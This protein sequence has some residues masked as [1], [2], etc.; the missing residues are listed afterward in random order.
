M[1][2]L[3]SVL[4]ISLLSALVT[5]PATLL[6]TSQRDLPVLPEC[7]AVLLGADAPDRSGAAITALEALRET[8]RGTDRAAEADTLYC[9]GLTHFIEGEFP[10]NTEPFR[11]A[12]REF[13]RALV[14]YR[15]VGNREGEARSQHQF[16]L[17][18]F[19]VGDLNNALPSLQQALRTAQAGDDP[20]VEAD[21]QYDLGLFYLERRQGRDLEE[22]AAAFDEAYS[23]YSR[24]TN[25][26]RQGDARVQQAETQFALWELDQA[27]ENFADAADIFNELE[28]PAQEATAI[29]GAAR[30]LHHIGDLYAAESAYNRALELY[31][32]AD[33]AAGQG[34]V[35]AA[36]GN[37]YF[38]SRFFDLAERT[39][40]EALDFNR[41]AGDNVGRSIT[42]SYTGELELSRG[43]LGRAIT[44]FENALEL[45]ESAEDIPAQA[46]A[47]LGLGN[48]R[49]EEARL[50]TDK[51]LRPALNEYGESARL[52]RDVLR[53]LY[54]TRRVFLNQAWAWFN[55]NP[56][57][58]N[59]YQPLF[60]EAINKAREVGDIRGE[61]ESMM[62][63]G[64]V[65]RYRNEFEQA[66][67]RFE[68]AADRAEDLG[69]PVLIG[70][71][72]LALG[73][74]EFLRSRYS[75]ARDRFETAQFNF[76]DAVADFPEIAVKEAVATMRQGDT[77][78]KLGL[79]RDAL[80]Y[81][82]RTLES[83]DS[84]RG[85]RLDVA[86]ADATNAYTSLAIGSL[87][88]ELNLF[89]QASTA[90]EE[91]RTTILG[92]E[93]RAA[94]ATVTALLGDLQFALRDYNSA[95]GS[96]RQAIRLGEQSGNVRAEALGLR[97]IG[98]IL[99]ATEDG[100]ELQIQ[101][102]YERALDR[103]RSISDVDGIRRVF[104]SMGE[105][106][107]LQNDLENAITYFAEARDNADEVGDLRNA[108]YAT[109][110]L[111]Y[112]YTLA[113]DDPQGIGATRTYEQALVQFREQDEY[114]GEG[115]ALQGLGELAMRRSQ[116]AAAIEYFQ[117]MES[118]FN[119]AEN[120][121]GQ[122]QAKILI[123]R[124][125]QDQR[126]LDLA[127]DSYNE[128][129]CMLQSFADV[130]ESVG[131]AEEA[132]RCLQD[133]EIDLSDPLVDVR[134]GRLA[135]AEGLRAR[136]DIYRE[137]EIYTLA[138]DDLS[139]AEAMIDGLA[140][141]DLAQGR[142]LAS[143]GDLA[144]DLNQ[145]QDA[146]QR[147]ENV[148][149]IGVRLRD[150]ST[151]GLGEYGLAR[152][153][154]ADPEE[155]DR[156]EEERT[157]SR[158][159]EL[160][161]NQA[162]NP[163]LA[164]QVAVSL[165]ESF[166]LRG[167]FQDAETWYLTARNEAVEAVDPVGEGY[168][169]LE[170]G[171]L[172]TSRFRFSEA[173]SDYSE[174]VRL[175]QRGEDDLGRGQALYRLAE[176]YLQQVSYL[177]SLAQYQEALALYE[178]NGDLIGQA[179]TL[180]R[181]GEAY[182]RQ[183]RLALALNQHFLALE[184]LNRAKDER[185]TSEDEIDPLTAAT[186]AR[187]L[188]NIGIVRLEMGQ[189]DNAGSALTAAL[190]L[191]VGSGDI[192]AETTTRQLIGRLAFLNGDYVGAIDIYN[193]VAR[194]LEGLNAVQTLGEL[195]ID[196]G[197]AEFRQAFGSRQ[198]VI[199]GVSRA[200]ISYQRALDVA[201]RLG[202][203]LLELKAQQSLGRVF[204]WL[205]QNGEGRDRLLTALDLADD[206][207]APTLR[208]SI[209]VDLG[210]LEEEAGN[211]TQAITYY[212]QAVTLFEDVYADIRLEPGQI[213]YASQ[214][215]LPYHRLVVL[216]FESEPAKALEYAE[217]GRARSLLYQFGTEQVDFG[218]GSDLLRA[219]QEQRQQIIGIRQQIEANALARETEPNAEERARLE[220]A[221]DD[222]RRTSLELQDELVIIQEQIDTQNAVLAQVTQVNVRS[223]AEIQADLAVGTTILSY[224][225]VPPNAVDQG[226]VYAFV[227]DQ[228]Q[229]EA[230]KLSV[231]PDTLQ[232]LVIDEFSAQRFE[233]GNSLVSLYQNLVVP[234]ESLLTNEQVVVVPHG[235]LNQ[236]PFSALT[237]DKQTFFNDDRSLSYAAS[238]TIYSLLADDRDAELGEILGQGLVFGNP[239]TPEF[240]REA[241]SGSSRG[242]L[243][244]LPGAEREAEDISELMQVSPLLEEDATE[245]ALWVQG[246][247]AKVIHIAAHGIFNP[248]NPLASFLALADDEDNDGSLQVREIYSLGLRE[249]QPLVVLSACDTAVG[250][251]SQS[252]DLQSL[253]G[254]FLISGARGV[255]ASLW[256]VDDDATQ[257][258]MT[259][260]YENLVGGE[261]TVAQALKAAQ[262][263]IRQDPRWSAPDYWAAF[264]LVGLPT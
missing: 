100:T 39:L 131:Q 181:I 78:M 201:R 126:R 119:N 180:T 253:S 203:K 50:S 240:F 228:E 111:A 210:L 211:R 239:T 130:T 95:E 40:E 191:A 147:F 26:E 15:E 101:E 219:W 114:E 99:V 213:A 79:Y 166:A 177:N 138:E 193:T 122:A 175:F 27:S 19:A 58:Q 198:S 42:L 117:Q 199:D 220:V 44:N 163:A 20:A 129:L 84:Y 2:R 162:P 148:R 189:L 88:L 182:R 154:T 234:V 204:N 157:Y 62:A 4:L 249:S 159:L 254:A 165:A 47:H 173:I 149:A 125:Q 49:A 57:R 72:N 235:V 195:Y 259:Y 164:R 51:V 67:I 60:E 207:E 200:R 94:E 246:R 76:E 141:N 263:S 232:T 217:R 70:D 257:A 32:A 109:L 127:L 169:L 224:Y 212:E 242:A 25:I 6:V 185:D 53:D 143:S 230:R 110:R 170:L 59:E 24:T 255:V 241:E 250:G 41:D 5:I 13:E 132:E 96:Y 30:V 209:L 251:S 197:D 80:E 151:Q 48:A 46:L 105:S 52:Y 243:L 187:I 61:I 87:Y 223:V 102:N 11:D 107:L 68:D 45:A 186:E 136:G 194:E 8:Q 145:F 227:L 238:A 188:R 229:F 55:V 65:Y 56:E 97:G 93:D 233:V 179:E 83:L 231:S 28:L 104:L 155:T 133:N 215:I 184:R 81:Y 18:Y 37:I 135:R 74:I 176:L 71:A 142:I 153:Y 183:S 178:S 75:E 245:S 63:L 21:I 69:D 89:E 237:P 206:I 140:L 86:L 262:Q 124:A 115:L 158:V 261:M 92:I 103:M 120:L 85:E 168:V 113:P 258:L 252:D 73:N 54:N 139:R 14:A 16:G 244:P 214:N 36:L 77:A 144:L 222:L 161:R 174:A 150:L 9:L 43:Q 264:V 192:F 146:R 90:L 247:N 121:T 98:A 190:D 118:A 66:G 256:K 196:L 12:R 208:A 171:A 91:A 156:G 7:V 10:D 31:Q 108:A 218:V 17:T 34:R 221:I 236:L 205:Q 248:Q 216:Y 134:L 167:R 123:G 112:T 226:S 225:V 128:A 82:G 160:F 152:L 3:T 1:R 137:L 64:E 172:R 29:H 35:L 260:F 22:A 33:D 23:A 38:R 106:A 116:Y 202:D